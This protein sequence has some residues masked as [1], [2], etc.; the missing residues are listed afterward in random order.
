MTEVSKV[1]LNGEADTSL[2]E[3]LAYSDET[4]RA[5]AEEMAISGQLSMPVVDRKTGRVC[6][7]IGALELLTARRRAIERESERKRS[8]QFDAR[9]VKAEASD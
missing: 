9:A 4:C 3:A 7:Q 8:F 5:V 2:P 1:E 6:G